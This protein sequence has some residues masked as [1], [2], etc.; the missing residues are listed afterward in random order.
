MHLGE[1][2]RPALERSHD[3]TH[4]VFD[5]AIGSAPDASSYHCF[6]DLHCV[7]VILPAGPR[8]RRC[9]MLGLHRPA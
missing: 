1:I 3:G 2:A 9:W 8:P 7:T 6:A 5:I 4:H